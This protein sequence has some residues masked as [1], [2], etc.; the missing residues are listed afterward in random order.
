LLSG[1]AQLDGTAGA[2]GER[3][4]HVEA[5]PLMLLKGAEKTMLLRL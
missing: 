2:G 3:H 5:E 1:E 4:Q